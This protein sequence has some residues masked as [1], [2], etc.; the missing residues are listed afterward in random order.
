MSSSDSNSS[1]IQQFLGPLY[2]SLAKD[3]AKWRTTKDWPASSLSLCGRYGLYRGLAGPTGGLTDEQS[4]DQDAP[5][6]AVDQIETLIQLAKADLLTTFVITQHLGAIKRIEAS[7]HDSSVRSNHQLHHDTL[8]SLLCGDQIASVGISHLTTS[9]LHLGRPAVTATPESGGYRIN[10]TIPWVTG[11]PKVNHIVVG[12]TLEDQTQIL[13]L[14]SPSSGGVQPGPGADMIAMSASCTDSVVLNNVLIPEDRVLSGPRGNVL[15]HVSK[16]TRPGEST[17]GAG[18]LQ[19]SALALGLSYAALEYLR[20]ES[21]KR[22]NLVGIVDRFEAEHRSLHVTIR[23]AADGR[24][25]ID[26]GKI[27]SAAN[28]LVQR[29]TSAAMTTAK[30]AGL[31]IDHPV[32]RWCQ[33][34]FFFLV[35]SCPQDVANA[36]L[37]DLVGLDS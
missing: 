16:P 17:T 26:S 18:G 30:G 35:W 9:R 25:N 15:S 29:T 1:S 36:H 4:S 11:A 13:V 6:S 12:A 14:L 37:C 8:T 20:D 5:W 3:A 33:Q 19:T 22:E 10:G 23:D 7:D 2:D 27:R 28:G 34:A 32:G 31:M 24:S 21:V